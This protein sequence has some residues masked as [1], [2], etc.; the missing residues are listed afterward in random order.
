MFVLC[1][2]SPRTA[3]TLLTLMNLVEVENGTVS[4]LVTGVNFARIG[5]EADVLMPQGMRWLL[6]RPHPI[7]GMYAHN[8]AGSV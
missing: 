3:L 8:G 2:R 7:E 4:G 1:S 5:I 6:L